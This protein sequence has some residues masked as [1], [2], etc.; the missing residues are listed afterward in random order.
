MGSKAGVGCNAEELAMPG[1][2]E[3][4]VLASCFDYNVPQ[5]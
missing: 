5:R 3:G 2:I 4:F 1:G